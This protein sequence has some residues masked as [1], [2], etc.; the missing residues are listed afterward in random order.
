MK[1]HKVITYLAN[2]YDSKR[3]NPKKGNAMTKPG[4]IFKND[5]LKYDM[6]SQRGNKLG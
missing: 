3:D 2:P 5:Y 1:K 6:T 4:K